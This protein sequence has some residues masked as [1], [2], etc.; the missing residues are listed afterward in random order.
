[1]KKGHCSL[2]RI[3]QTQ[4]MAILIILCVPSAVSGETLSLE[5]AV[6]LALTRN[7]RALAAGEQSQ[8]ASGRLVQARAYFFPAV[9]LTG[10]YTRR[11]Y[12]VERD[13]NGESITIQSR[14]AIS[15]TVSL[16]WILFNPVV[17]PSYRQALF[18]DRAQ[19]YS[20]ADARRLL[21]FEV[22]A[23]YLTT[24]TMDQ[25][26]E[27]AGHRL[28]YAGKTLDAARA[29]YAAGLVSVNDV[30]RAELEY[31]TAEM[32]STQAQGEVRTAYLQLGFLLDTV[33]DGK[34]TS[35]ELMLAQAK[36]PAAGAED[37]LPGAQERRLDLRALTW[38]ARAQRALVL[39]PKFEWLP[40]LSLTGQY[41]YTNEAGLTG[42][43]TSWSAGLALSWPLFDGFG[44]FGAFRERQA[45]ARLAELDLRASGRQLE[46]EVRDALVSLSSQQA[47]LKMALVAQ[48]AARKN[49]AEIAELYRQGLSNALQVA[50]A[51]VRLFEAEVEVARQRNGLAL[52]LLNLRAAQGLDPFGKEPSL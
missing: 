46:L 31:S 13:L 50:D 17:I 11:P 7:E 8:A 26:Q 37:L 45:Q 29:R 14:N 28:E 23:A 49:A 1:M 6:Q 32:G 48:D 15:G 35:P 52:A 20:S 34:L 39:E 4:L 21:A 12:E 16:N 42:R 24:L 25:V 10:S 40:S 33:I 3:G 38:N 44:R 22:A 30:T 51:N 2:I 19:R 41:R 5:Q 18:A 9:S 47:S 27:A 36:L 43:S